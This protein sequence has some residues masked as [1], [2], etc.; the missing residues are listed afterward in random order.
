MSAK[1]SVRIRDARDRLRE[2]VRSCLPQDVS[3]EQLGTVDSAVDELLTALGESRSEME[4]EKTL[5]AFNGPPGASRP[6]GFGLG[7]GNGQY[8]A[9]INSLILSRQFFEFVPECFLLTD[10]DGNILQVNAAA[11][12][13]FQTSREFLINRPLPFFFPPDVRWR[14]YTALNNLRR[15]QSCDWDIRLKP[16]QGELLDLTV[17]GRL[18]VKADGTPAG[19]L[20]LLR[21]TT[22]HKQAEE[23]LRAQKELSD[24]LVDTA[25]AIVLVLDHAGVV[26]R[27][28]PYIRSV[29]GWP[30]HE[31]REHNW[32]QVLI[33]PSHQATA[34]DL[35]KS[36]FAKGICTSHVVP[37]VTRGGELR[38]VAWSGKVLWDRNWAP[39]A[40]LV[41]HDVTD[42]L[43]AQRQVLQAERLAFL[44]Q[45]MAS[46]AH[47]SRGILQ[48]AQ[49]CLERLNWRLEGQGETLDL[50]TRAQ[51]ALDDLLRLHEDVRTFA[52]PMLV[53]RERCHLG[54][55]WRQAWEES[56]VS[57]AH[58]EVFRAEDTTGID[59]WCEADPFRLRMVF[60]NIFDNALAACPDLVQVTISCRVTSLGDMAAVQ[61]SVRDNGPGLS[62]E[63]KRRIFEPFFTNKP[64]GSGLG[65]AIADRIIRAHGG[66]LTVGEDGPGAVIHIILPR[67]DHGTLSANRDR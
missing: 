57:Q 58:R 47:E 29:S 25:Q 2:V 24:S 43:E 26:Q 35:L 53:A 66:Q 40:L 55:V 38:T 20:W 22:A 48:R 61:V 39:G 23:E 19:L 11:V 60:R 51:G 37:L 67:T 56:M 10:A 15:G 32:C 50:V 33:P 5:P 7:E 13:L 41:G 46:L 12:L 59:L 30:L 42:L 8:D 27:C 44:G 54:E 18:F 9:S 34:L 17:V 52:A 36:T 65:M 28:N 1:E 14:F 49:A 31:V 3:G 62:A 6:D 45:M 4:S 21:N 16:A 64:Q 63:E